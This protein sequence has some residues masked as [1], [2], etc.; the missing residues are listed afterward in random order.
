MRSCLIKVLIDLGM[1]RSDTQ[2]R[3]GSD[4]GIFCGSGIGQ[5]RSKS[6]IVCILFCVIVKPH[7]MNKNIIK[8]QKISVHYVSSVLKLFHS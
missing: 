7:E 6:D 8:H 4:T 5:T 3:I 2:Y 1:H